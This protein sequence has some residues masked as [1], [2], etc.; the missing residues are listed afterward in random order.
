MDRNTSVR[1]AGVSRVGAGTRAGMQLCAPRRGRRLQGKAPQVVE[2]RANQETG[3]I[4]AFFFLGFFFFFC[5]FFCL[6]LSFCFVRGAGRGGEPGLPCTRRGTPGARLRSPAPS[7]MHR[8]GGPRG[9][10]SRAFLGRGASP[11]PGWG[12][13]GQEGRGRGH[14]PSQRWGGMKSERPGGVPA[15]G[16]PGPRTPP[17]PRRPPLPRQE[18]WGRDPLLSVLGAAQR[19]NVHDPLPPAGAP[20][21]RALRRGPLC[22]ARPPLSSRGPPAAPRWVEG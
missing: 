12:P 5:I 21:A 16:L 17:A 18:G 2:I 7:T 14:A 3:R 22:P 1:A 11:R 6:L 15:S 8:W 13:L 9:P 19:K 4:G 20:P 10:G